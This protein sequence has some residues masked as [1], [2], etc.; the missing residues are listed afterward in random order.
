M[1]MSKKE[2]DFGY[3]IADEDLEAIKSN[4]FKSS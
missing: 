1:I 2:L 4:V 3:K